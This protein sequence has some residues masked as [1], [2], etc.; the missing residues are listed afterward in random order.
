MEASKKEAYTP[1]AKAELIKLE[2][3]LT[4]ALEAAVGYS[5]RAEIA[6]KASTALGM[7]DF[8]AY[9]ISEDVNTANNV[10]H[11][12][13]ALTEGES[14]F[15]SHSAVNVWRGDIEENG[16]A[17]MIC[18]YLQELRHPEFVLDPHILDADL[19]FF[20]YPPYVTA[21]TALSGKEL[22]YSLNFPSKSISGLP[23]YECA[24][25]GRNIATYDTIEED[26]VN[27]RLGHIFHIISEFVS[28]LGEGLEL[29]N[30]PEVAA[31]DDDDAYGFYS[32]SD[33]TI[34]LNRQYFDDPV[35]LVNTIAHEMRH[36]YQEYRAGLLET[37][38]DALYRVNLDNYI[39]PIPL[40]GGGWL[41]FTDYQDQYVE[42]DARAF[43]NLFTEAMKYE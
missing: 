10:A 21:T 34:N 2:S 29:E 9:V 36:A 42:V 11:S 39:S 1:I 31:F 15:L 35:E 22:A 5:E 20:A 37:R 19:G 13:L 26:T 17:K 33:N 32:P 30:L 8:A 25:F 41:F 28:A 43:A 16:A 27:I 14:S 38:E 12:Y 24:E 7:W 4:S 3:E 6:D 18:G 23:I 40:P